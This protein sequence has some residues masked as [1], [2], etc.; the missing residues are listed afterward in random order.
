MKKNRLIFYAILICFHI[1]SFV[2]TILIQDIT[3]ISKIY[4]YIKSFKYVALLGLGLVI[5]DLIW[6][7]KAARNNEKEKT[8]LQGELNNLKAKLFDLQEALQEKQQKPQ[9]EK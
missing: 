8:S 5:V 7:Y 9:N 2:F 3:F 1:A 4:E 6:S